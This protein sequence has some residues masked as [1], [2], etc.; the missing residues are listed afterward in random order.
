MTGHV[1]TPTPPAPDVGVGRRA[2]ALTVTALA[3]GGFAIGTAEFMMM[4]LLPLVAADLGVSVPVASSAITAY[5]VG[6]VVGAPTLTALATRWSPRPVLLGMTALFLVGNVLCA[7]APDATA[8]VAARFVTAL[9]HGAYFGVATVVARSVALP[10]RAASA[11]GTLMAGLAIANVVGVPAATAL[12]QAVGWRVPFLVVAGLGALTALGITVLV[13]RSTAARVG[14]RAELAVFRQP[15]VWLFLA[16]VMTGFSALFAV[17]SFVAP[18]LE[19]RT[20]LTGGGLA[21]ALVVF[22]VGTVVGTVLGGRLA[23]RRSTLVMVGSLTSTAVLLAVLVLASTWAPTALATLFA[24]G[25]VT[26]G[27]GPAFQ[28]RVIRLAG[29][30]GSL[31]SAA[32]HG[33]FN[34]A[35]AIGA[36]LGALVLQAGLGV[37]APL[38]VGVGASLTGLAVLS[39]ALRVERR[40]RPGTP[41]TGELPQQRAS[42]S[43]TTPVTAGR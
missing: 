19:E 3:V 8:L 28:D 32:T 35:N 5:A 39:V 26:F 40:R 22:G 10:G 16:V 38:W 41:A 31:V 6:V 21:W 20:G 7:V 4:G 43:R 42:S 1:R 24:L 23:D 17:H 15:S 9:V 36:V 33:A 30:G 12:G 11:V 29:R 18:L 37:T 14:L 2:A 34:L 25:V 13:P 27:A